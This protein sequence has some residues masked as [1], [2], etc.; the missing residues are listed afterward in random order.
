MKKG[1]GRSKGK[2]FERLIAKKFKEAFGHEFAPTPASGGLRWKDVKNTRGDI[3]TDWEEWPY[4]IECKK[5]EDWTFDTLPITDKNPLSLWWKQCCDDAEVVEK[6]PV[7]IFSKNRRPIYVMRHYAGRL[8]S[9]FRVGNLDLDEN[10]VCMKINDTSVKVELF[11][12]FLVNAEEE[13]EDNAE[14][15]TDSSNDSE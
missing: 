2:A 5:C 10:F 15:G 8:D 14:R 3:V 6:E 1:G 4:N 12:K 9:D 7:L 13:I 11:E